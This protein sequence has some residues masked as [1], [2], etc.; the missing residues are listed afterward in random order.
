MSLLLNSLIVLT[1][2]V[3]ETLEF[4]Y[5]R[6]SELIFITWI[7]KLPGYMIF[8]YRAHLKSFY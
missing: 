3:G 5:L 6:R 2:D 4:L 7:P 8:W 1:W